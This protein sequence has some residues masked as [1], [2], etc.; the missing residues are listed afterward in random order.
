MNIIE[1]KE[2]VIWCK[3]NKVKSFSHEGVTF[4]LSDLAF[5][6]DLN[7]GTNLPEG[8]QAVSDKEHRYETLDTFAETEEMT[9]EEE[10]DLLFWSSN[11]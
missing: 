10:E 11:K 5:I 7:L 2:L 4:E 8:V 1:I 6:E 3:K 9:P